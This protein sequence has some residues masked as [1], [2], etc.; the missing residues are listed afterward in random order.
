[1]LI[2]LSISFKPAFQIQRAIMLLVYTLKSV[3]VLAASFFAKNAKAIVLN[4]PI[5]A[6]RI[7]CTFSMS[8]YFLKNT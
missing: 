3:A 1:M 2:Q 8:K 4:I 7:H 6:L 5:S